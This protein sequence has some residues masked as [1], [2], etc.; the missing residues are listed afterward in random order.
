M[1]TTKAKEFKKK[2]KDLSKLVKIEIEEYIK[3]FFKDNNININ[4]EEWDN[5]YRLPKYIIYS[6][7]Q[8]IAKQYYPPYPTKRDKDVIKQITNNLNQIK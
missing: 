6:I 5:D 8:E 3:D 4:M 7:L 2:T 1:E